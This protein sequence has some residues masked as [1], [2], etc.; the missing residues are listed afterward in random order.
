M[1]VIANDPDETIHTPR[2][3]VPGKERSTAV[4]GT[5]TITTPIDGLDE[6]S[7][8]AWFN[9]QK[10]YENLASDKDIADRARGFL[11]DV[12]VRYRGAIE[13]LHHRWEVV[14]FATRGNTFARSMTGRPPVH[15]PEMYK[16]EQ[17]LF[18]R[19]NEAI[20]HYPDWFMA[21][22][23]ERNDQR[24]DRTI[25]DFLR[26]QLDRAKF[27]DLV[28]PGFQQMLRTG[29]AVYKVYHSIETRNV[30]ERDVRVVYQGDKARYTITRKEKK[31]VVFEG[32]RIRLIDPFNLL[33]DLE[34]SSI[35][36]ADFV[37]DSCEM[38]FDEIAELGR[39]GLFENWEE[40]RDQ[41]G[42]RDPLTWRG[43]QSRGPELQQR[44]SGNIK[45]GTKKF[46]VVDIW[47]LF[48]AFGTG[49]TREFVITIADS[50]VILRVQEN[51]HDDKHRPYAVARASKE[52]FRFFNVAP[53]DHAVH[54]QITMDEHY[55][56]A[57]DSQRLSVQ[58]FY[59]VDEGANDIPDSLL[60]IEPG[61]VFRTKQPPTAIVP[62]PILN[63]FLGMQNQFRLDM[64]EIYGAPRIMQ[65]TEGGNTAT[66]VERKTMEGN[67]RAGGLVRAFTGCME[68]ILQKMHALN[69]QYVTKS[70]V[71]RVLGKP[72]A[73][74]AQYSEIG[75]EILDVDL[76]FEFMGPSNLQHVGMRGTQYQ[77]FAA[78]A[79]P[80]VANDPNALNRSELVSELFTAMVGSRPASDIVK[81][82]QPLD[83]MLPAEEE[84]ILLLQGQEVPIHE[85]DNDEEHLR[86][87]APIGESPRFKRLS[88]H[89]QQY[90][91]KH[92]LM[93]EQAMERKRVMA[94]AKERVQPGFPASAET[95]GID[96]DRGTT[97]ERGPMIGGSSGPGQTPQGETPGPARGGAVRSGDR[98]G[99]LFQQENM[100]A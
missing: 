35:H 7:M 50:R 62:P 81:S 68:Q 6:D 52:A 95:A 39:Q 91:V 98:E 90:Y 80:W 93:H 76:D 69:Q 13:P 85:A 15:V 44:L 77:Q 65:G 51:P 54:M 20:F 78:A 59:W 63:Q 18:P 89:S 9:A 32:P 21:R 24:Q 73:K 28:E 37:G 82:P 70:Q 97:G 12:E 34:A 96:K 92:M 5:V 67:K 33:V 100:I 48:D 10:N 14:N 87:H 75:P 84:N 88:P 17:T 74:L 72:G 71:F 11:K 64:E 1:T 43:P 57:M 4:E 86:T 41:S 42:K 58:P 49:E 40:L 3:P 38:T 23:R 29:V 66:E 55:N 2:N 94:E 46:K 83:E 27:D 16:M 61:K 26:Y 79:Y 53:A 56:L 60:N 31:K 47:C 30:I 45:Y 99:G 8:D 19:L 36:D 22:G 25:T